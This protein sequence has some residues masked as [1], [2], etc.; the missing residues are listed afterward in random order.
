VSLRFVA[1]FVA[2][3]VLPLSAGAA[4]GPLVVFKATTHTPKVNVK[5]P[6]SITVT[7]G[8]KPVAGT[9]T[10]QVIDPFG[11]VHAV[12]FGNV[13]NRFVTNV[14]FNGR[15]SDFVIYPSISQGVR[16]TFRVTV[17]TALGKRV[18]NYWAQAR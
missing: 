17:K 7:K 15:F 14:K 1:I 3:L 5:W 12:E 6:W 8:G 2:A 16:V 13:K 10:A 18:V 9:V 11:G 4:A